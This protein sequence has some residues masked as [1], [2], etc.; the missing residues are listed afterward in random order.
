MS[1]SETKAREENTSL[2]REN[3][4]LRERI[5]M[6]EK[7]NELLSLELNRVIQNAEI[8]HDGQLH[9]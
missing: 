2:R 6:L 8:Q 5:Q 4:E 7:K 1:K 3:R 9:S